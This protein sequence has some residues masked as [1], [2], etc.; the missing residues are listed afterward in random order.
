[1][2]MSMNPRQMMNFRHRRNMSS[3]DPAVNDSDSDDDEDLELEEE[4][5]CSIR[6]SDRLPNRRRPADVDG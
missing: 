2:M 1:M 5:G 4:G 3:I 6:A